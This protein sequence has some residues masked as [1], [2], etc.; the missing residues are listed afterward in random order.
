MAAFFLGY[1]ES[2]E[3][4]QP[5][6]KA[7]F[8]IHKDSEKYVSYVSFADGDDE[9]RVEKAGPIDLRFDVPPQEAIDYFKRKRIL[10]KPEFNKLSREAKAG[11]FA[12]SG[13][14]QQ[15]ILESFRKQIETS[16]RD[17]ATQKTVVNKLKS[18]LDGAG[19]KELGDFHLETVVRSNLMSAYGLG[20]RK[21][22]EEVSDLLP[23][24]QRNAVNDD[25]TRPAHRALDGVVF[26]AKPRILE[27]ALSSGRF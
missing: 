26:P 25:R 2:K 12:V 20:R 24:W 23:Y 3:E 7:E 10:T 4:T 17:G 1:D 22:M 9:K 27:H 16:L 11:A 19:H 5:K 21:Q 18:I 13:I 15:D 14:Y 8:S 6:I